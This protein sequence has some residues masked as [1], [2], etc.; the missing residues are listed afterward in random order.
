M[1]KVSKRVFA[2]VLVISLFFS[3]DYFN[4]FA[5]E[6]KK[7]GINKEKIEETISENMIDIET[8]SENEISELGDDSEDEYKPKLPAFISQSLPSS[9]ISAILFPSSL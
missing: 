9:N 5:K 4:V 1:K 6:I 3:N 8:D 7:E 2:Y